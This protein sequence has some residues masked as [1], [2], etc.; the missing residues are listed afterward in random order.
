M[1]AP[2]NSPHAIP[3]DSIRNIPEGYYNPDDLKLIREFTQF[4]LIFNN[5]FPILHSTSLRYLVGGLGDA[6]RDQITNQLRSITDAA[7]NDLFATRLA[8]AQACIMYI[9]TYPYLRYDIPFVLVRFV[10]TVVQYF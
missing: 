5:E 1:S 10:L 3:Q 4:T 6:A 8:M 9:Q 7:T 2:R